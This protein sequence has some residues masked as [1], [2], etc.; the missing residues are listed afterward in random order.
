MYHTAPC[1]APLR[2]VV[3]SVA[4]G[5]FRSVHPP[6]AARGRSICLPVCSFLC[7][8]VRLFV[9]SFVRMFVCLFAFSFFAAE[10]HSFS[11]Q[12]GGWER[13][14]SVWERAK[15][16]A[17][18]NYWDRVWASRYVRPVPASSSASADGANVASHI[19]T[20]T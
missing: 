5:P 11:A 3:P 9:C 20:E 15:K 10:R 12:G 1:H 14:R 2:W 19:C 13:V 7:S 18:G 17:Y 6:A 4:S 16:Y 8:F